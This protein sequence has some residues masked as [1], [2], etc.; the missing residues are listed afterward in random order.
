MVIP[1]T[2]AKEGVP[3]A[4]AVVNIA[5]AGAA[6]AT[7]LWTLSA[8]ATRVGRTYVKL[9][10]LI[11]RANGIGTN[12]WFQLGNGVAGAYVD[13]ITPR[14]LVDNTDNEFDLN[15]IVSFATVTG[16]PATL[17]AGSVDAQVLVDELS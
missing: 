11:V 16:F 14:R 17:P 15:G 8:A 6:N 4:G 3:L 9:N 13:L 5:V 10:K 1:F 7:T 12:V 2:Q